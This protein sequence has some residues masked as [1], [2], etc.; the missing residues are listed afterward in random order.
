M[1]SHSLVSPM[2]RPVTWLA[3]VLAAVAAHADTAPRIQVAITLSEGKATTRTYRMVTKSGELVVLHV[4][5]QVALP[6]STQSAQGGRSRADAK[7]TNELT[8]Q[9]IGFIARVE[10][11]LGDDGRID[12]KAQVEDSSLAAGPRTGAPGRPPEIVTLEEN[13]VLT[14]DDGV[15]QEALAI[16]RADAEPV[17]ITITARRIP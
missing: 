17:T 7:A 10:A 1:R 5:S 4:G 3:F 16:E 11:R 13:L 2:G 9:S 12:L 15:P 14:L 6:A 8:Y